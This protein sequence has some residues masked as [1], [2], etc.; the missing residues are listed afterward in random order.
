MSKEVE[1]KR[2]PGKKKILAQIKR[3]QNQLDSIMNEEIYW[4]LKKTQQRYFESANKP[5]K[6]LASQIKKRQKKRNT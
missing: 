4:Q 6:L 3:L 1:L 2:R 5:G